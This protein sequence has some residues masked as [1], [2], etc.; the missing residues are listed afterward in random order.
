MNVIAALPYW[1]P[2]PWTLVKDLPLIHKPL[3]VHSFGMLVAIG[4]ITCL[5]AASWRGEKK[6]GFSG[7][8]V[9]NFGIFLIV[10]GWIFSHIFNVITYEPQRVAANPMVIFEVWGSISSYGGLIGGI[11]AVFIWKAT[12]KD[13]DLLKWADHAAWGIPIAYFFGRMGCSSVH[14]H[15]GAIAPDGWPLAFIFPDGHLRH[16]L[17]FY[18]MWWWLAIIAIV[19]WLDRKPRPKG[20]FL[21]VVFML[22]APVRFILDFMR[23]WPRRA[24]G[25]IHVNAFVDVFLKVLH[26]QPEAYVYGGGDARYLGLTPAQYV[27]IAIFTIGL[28]IYLKV[29]NNPPM[30]W[31][32]YKRPAR[33][34]EASA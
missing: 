6:M 34:E 10:F 19:F 3:Q 25:D 16:D 14:D 31:Q 4:L 7:E 26:V 22:Y 28:I 8:Q 17:G 12:H 32:R 29:R 9:Q 27:S 21:G 15:P 13:I 11:I 24:A 20:F 18:E 5:T 1:H 30:E 23:V 2:G 33:Q